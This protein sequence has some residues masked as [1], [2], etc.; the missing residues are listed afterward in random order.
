MTMTVEPDLFGLPGAARDLHPISHLATD[1]CNALS[2]LY[3]YY[4]QPTTTKACK[5]VCVRLL[6]IF[7]TDHNTVRTLELRSVQ[8]FTRY[9][10]L[11][12]NAWNDE[13][14][15]VGRLDDAFID[16]MGNTQSNS[17][18]STGINERNRL[19]ATAKKC[20]VELDALLGPLASK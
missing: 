8:D 20:I 17:R 19:L 18:Q 5:S 9:G 2:G 13:I 10:S 4:E 15:R 12:R 11:F 7:N 3:N 14:R 6:E 16:F 1:L